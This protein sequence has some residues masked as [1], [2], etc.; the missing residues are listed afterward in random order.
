MCKIFAITRHSYDNNTEAWTEHLKDGARINSH[1]SAALFIDEDT[2]SHS[3]IRATQWTDIQDVLDFKSDWTTV[4][5]HQ[6]FGTRGGRGLENVHF[7]QANDVFYCHNGVLRGTEQEALSVDSLVIGQ[8]LEEGGVWYALSQ[9]QQQDYANV[10]MVDMIDG[11]YYMSRSVTNSLYTNDLG[12][13]STDK[14]DG[15]CDISVA[16]NTIVKREFELNPRKS[17]SQFNWNGWNRAILD[18]ADDA[19]EEAVRMSIHGDHP[20][21]D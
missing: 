18:D 12:D 13:Y 4:F 17:S 1:G 3:I 16:E 2:G 7:W 19:Y 15:I 9:L 5:I 21:E 11:A 6:R 8:W 14:L 20:T 10:F